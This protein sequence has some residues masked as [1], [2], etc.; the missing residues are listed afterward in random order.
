M[1][2]VQ[3]VSSQTTLGPAQAMRPV[4]NDARAAFFSA[5][6][7]N[8]IE[9]LFFLIP[10]YDAALGSLVDMRGRNGLHL[11]I[12]RGHDSIARLLIQYG[13]THPDFL[14]AKD[15]E[16]HTPLMCAQATGRSE[17]VSELRAAGATLPFEG[18]FNSALARRAAV[19]IRPDEGLPYLSTIAFES[20]VLQGDKAAAFASFKAGASP[21]TAMRKF[22]LDGQWGALDWLIQ[23]AFIGSKEALAMLAQV[24]DAHNSEA[25]A[26]LIHPKNVLSVL[27]TMSDASSEVKLATLKQFTRAGAWPESLVIEAARRFA[28]QS[29]GDLRHDRRILELLVTHG[30]PALAALMDHAEK[31]H[32]AVVHAIVGSGTRD[33]ITAH[34]AFRQ[35]GNTEACAL[36]ERAMI[37]H[38][39]ASDLPERE[40]LNVL[41]AIVHAGWPA[42]KPLLRDKV[43]A[44]DFRDAKLL[45]ASGV[46]ATDLLIELASTD[47]LDIAA[48]L[49]LLGG[50]AALAVKQLGEQSAHHAAKGEQ[51]A[52]R[53]ARHAANKLASLFH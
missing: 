46:S 27:A 18:P 6:S 38:A 47:R 31:G 4:P 49:I 33:A 1:E 51:D 52:A 7:N 50:N 3:G 39:L 48:D 14:E 17:L 42:A 16:G 21:L 34:T 11:A 30:A 24:R 26:K 35:Q 40:R 28:A 43:L 15:R 32:A 12:E 44:G 41:G 8:D 2:I 36:V 37:E 23:N 13:K 29:A 5:I 53:L 25:V 10:E 19:G 45:I 22:I 20:A 9:S